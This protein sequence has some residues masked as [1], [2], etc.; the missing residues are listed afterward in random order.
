MPIISLNSLFF[1]V[2]VHDSNTVVEFVSNASIIIKNN[3]T[4]NG[5][6]I[7]HSNVNCGGYDVVHINPGVVVK[8]AT[9]IIRGTFIL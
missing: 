1:L 9:I 3:I 5:T 7:L 8:S 6:I 4:S 2:V